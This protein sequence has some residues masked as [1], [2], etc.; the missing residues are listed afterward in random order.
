MKHD[1]QSAGCFV[2]RVHFLQQQS[3]SLAGAFCLAILVAVIVVGTVTGLANS[4]CGGCACGHLP[5]PRVFRNM[6]MSTE[7]VAN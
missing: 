3:S 6:G 1:V 7:F 5:S 4:G 2:A